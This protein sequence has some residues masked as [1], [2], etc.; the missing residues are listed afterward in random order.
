[1][2]P[3]IRPF[4]VF[5]RTALRDPETQEQYP[6]HGVF[7]GM[8]LP[9]GSFLGFY[10][11]TFRDGEYRGKDAYTFSLSDMHI[12]PKK[13]KGAV[14]PTRYPLA[15]LNEPPPNVQANVFAIE[16]SKADGVLP[17]LAK[18]QSIAALGFYT[19]RRVAGGE[20]LYV[21]Y[22]SKYFRGHYKNPEGVAPNSL[23]G[24]ACM[25]KKN[26]RET[27]AQ[28]MEAFGLHYVDKECYE[29]LA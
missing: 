8:D 14:D 5:G 16:F 22:G 29:V 13:T 26:E 19:C 3:F 1:M 12:R 17:F 6:F 15:M 28:M 18:R 24:P 2:A 4:L 27:P 20:E 7:A 21:N 10:N 11:G 25:L 23:V 9:A